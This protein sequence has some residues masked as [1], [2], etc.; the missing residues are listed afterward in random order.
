MTEIVGDYAQPN[1]YEIKPSTISS[2]GSF[3]FIFGYIVYFIEK[4]IIITRAAAFSKRRKCE[5]GGKMILKP[6]DSSN[7][8]RPTINNKMCGSNNQ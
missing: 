4:I 1:S 6:Y 8:N 2:P 7:E 3:P 5:L